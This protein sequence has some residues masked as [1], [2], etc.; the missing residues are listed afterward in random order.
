MKRLLTKQDRDNSR[1]YQ[2]ES[3]I[4]N[5]YQKIEHK[6]L[7]VFYHE[8]NLLLKSFWGTAANHTDFFKYRT[9]EQMMRKLEDL[10]QTAD[11]R[12]VR[13]AEEK[14]RNKGKSSS[15]AATAAAIR[16]ELKA[17]FPSVK[18]SVTSDSF[19]MGNSVNASWTDGPTTKEI[20]NIIGKYQYGHFN[21]MEDIYEYTNSRTVIP[22]AKYVRSE[23][24][25]SD[26]VL[27]SVKEQL[28]L[29][30]NF[31]SAEWDNSLERVAY[32]LLYQ[33][34]F[35]SNYLSFKVKR[36]DVT[37]TSGIENFFAIDFETEQKPIKESKPVQTSEQKGK[38][39]IVDYS[40]KAFAVIGGLSSHYEGLINL[41]GSY[42]PRLKCGKG[43]IFSKKKLEQVKTY[44]TAT[45][46]NKTQEIEISTP[47]ALLNTNLLNTN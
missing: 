17:L 11:A 45:K 34:S 44:L 12:E 7:I 27:N 42:N 28:S 3:L 10:K 22:Q 1:K 39:Q 20:D 9:L 5:G 24:T 36:N 31:D 6:N 30:W 2:F 8:T 13:K 46:P 16:T 25:I 4:K 26:A 29:L 33:T 37:A 19:S 14:E 47:L 40:E 23:R 15:H 18:F 38:I 21:G 35:P 43:I 41:G 32:R